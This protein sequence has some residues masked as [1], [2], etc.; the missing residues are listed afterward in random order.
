[1]G[2]KSKEI[3]CFKRV[4]KYKYNK[5]EIAQT[6]HNVLLAHEKKVNYKEECPDIVIEGD[7]EIIGIEHCLVDLLFQTKRKSA[8]S[9]LRRQENEIVRKVNYYKVN[10]EKLSE[11]IENGSAPDFVIGKVEEL[12]N[13]QA[14]F[15][16][17]SFI[18][19]FVTVTQDHNK[20]ARKYRENLIHYNQQ[21]SLGCL[22]EIPYYKPCEYLVMDKK[23]NKHLIYLNG[24]PLTEDMVIEIGHLSG[25]DFVIM[26]IYCENSTYSKDKYTKVYYFLPKC[27]KKCLIEQGIQLKYIS[28]EYPIKEKIKIDKKRVSNGYMLETKIF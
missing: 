9:L 23:Y 20:K 5:G 21:V 24:I 11:D 27:I 13:Y 18:N 12:H 14:D 4:L 8:Q 16:Y 22:I 19:N 10:P 17:R 26:C 6:I 1:M 25:F 7:R 28:F 15:D 2:N 3:E